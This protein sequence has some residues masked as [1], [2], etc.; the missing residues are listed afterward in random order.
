VD[1]VVFDIVISVFWSIELHNKGMG[2]AVL[3]LVIS[4][5][6]FLLCTVQSRTF[7][8]SGELFVPPVNDLMYGF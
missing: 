5:G 1:R 4:K 8:F 7:M 3:Y 6:Q 2:Y